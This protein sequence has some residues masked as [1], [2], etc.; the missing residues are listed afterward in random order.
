MIPEKSQF[1]DRESYLGAFLLYKAA[2]VKYN[3]FLMMDDL[4]LYYR[5]PFS[6]RY[7]SKEMRQIWGELTKRKLWR[8]LW[9]ILAET[10]SEYGLVTSE[11]VRDLS[12]H[13][14]QIN[15]QRSLEIEAEI[16]HDLMA[17]IKAFAEQCPI[18]GG[19]IHLGATSM[20]IKDNADVLRIR[21]SLQLIIKKLAELLHL[22]ANQIETFADL[23]ILA[24]THLQPAEPTTLGYRFAQYGQDLLEDYQHLQQ[25]Y[26]DLRLKGFR[27]AVGSSATFSELVG[28]GYLE[29]F[30]QKLAEKLG[31][32]VF[33]VVTQVYPR[34]QDYNLACALAGMGA[35]L[36]RF[37]LD[38]RFLQSMPIGE[39]SEPFE[40]KQV[41]S[42]AMPF[43]RNPIN[44]EKINSLARMLA[45]YPRLAW[46]NAANSLLE[47]T[48][49][50]SANRR[51]MLPEMF[52]ISDELLTTITRLVKGMNIYP[53]VIQRNLTIYAPFAATE[54]LMMAAA[55][56]GINR[57]TLH[58]ELRKL[59][60]QAWQAIKDGYP[61]PLLELVL[62]NTLFQSALSAT[63]IRDLMNI[64]N[65][66]GDAALRARKLGD[67]IRQA[68]I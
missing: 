17:E 6:W 4:N 33:D 14:D 61:N 34:K 48:L 43:K 51:T 56:S 54:R 7:G 57:Q 10:Q 60:M 3:S 21:Q 46:D 24:F 50:D 47:N 42:S 58:E 26:Q 55:K 12:E 44:A 18:G 45:Q 5:S 8:Q 65:Y 27:G 37:A 39:W 23:P 2:W 62:Q 19:I 53:E 36:H 59:S 15:L 64:E 13:A 68:L 32:P 67:R 40:E 52:L 31:M 30:Q 25:V 63:E 49:D 41:G 20:D 22:I 38:W 11:Q 16:H 29:E 35:S 66:I 9:V 28:E 1:V